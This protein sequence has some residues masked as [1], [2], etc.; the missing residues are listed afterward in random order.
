VYTINH[1]YPEYYVPL[2]DEC[3]AFS[4]VCPEEPAGGYL[5]LLFHFL[6]ACSRVAEEEPA[7]IVCDWVAG[8]FL[9]MGDHQLLVHDPA[10]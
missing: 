10:A 6:P 1:V 9:G 5:L 7:G 4:H 8:S 3:A 2:L